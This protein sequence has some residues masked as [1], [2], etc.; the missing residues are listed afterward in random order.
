[1]ADSLFFFNDIYFWLVILIDSEINTY[2][3]NF[4]SK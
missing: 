1:M 2:A 3:K 4:F